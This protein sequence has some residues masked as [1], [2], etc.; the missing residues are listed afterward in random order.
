MTSLIV[1]P[2]SLFGAYLVSLECMN[3]SVF[4]RSFKVFYNFYINLKNGKNDGKIDKIFRVLS[5][6]MSLKSGIPR[7]SLNVLAFKLKTKGVQTPHDGRD[8]SDEVSSVLQ[9]PP[10]LESVSPHSSCNVATVFLHSLFLGLLVNIDGFIEETLLLI[11]LDFIASSLVD[12]FILWKEIYSNSDWRDM[13]FSFDRSFTVMF[14]FENAF[15]TVRK[16]DQS[17]FLVTY[18]TFDN[19]RHFGNPLNGAFPREGSDQEDEPENFV[20]LSPFCSPMT[21]KDANEKSYT[22]ARLKVYIDPQKGFLF[23][24]FILLS[25]DD[26]DIDSE[27]EMMKINISLPIRFCE[28]FSSPIVF[29]F[30]ESGHYAASFTIKIG[31]E[32]YNVLLEF[33]EYKKTR[34]DHYA[35]HYVLS[36]ISDINTC[37][38][39]FCRCADAEELMGHGMPRVGIF[40]IE[41]RDFVA[42]ETDDDSALA[43]ALRPFPEDLQAFLKSITWRNPEAAGSTGSN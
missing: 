28:S 12:H 4:A 27:F 30:S 14:L 15:I 32:H 19:P 3:A 33:D 16:N 17:D 40:S 23:F 29:Y 18:Q 9:S 21:L 24:Y 11:E 42:P 13:C 43:D 20:E 10:A 36:A 22:S 38:T 25:F 31:N 37:T 8:L 7:C 39:F 2:I 41:I 34:V 6:N 1:N 5:T 26:S 35:G